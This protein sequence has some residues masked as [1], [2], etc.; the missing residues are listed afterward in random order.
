M[1]DFGTDAGDDAIAMR[2]RRTAHRRRLARISSRL[3][4][5][6]KMRHTSACD[7]HTGSQCICG[8]SQAQ[9]CLA[10]YRV[11]VIHEGEDDWEAL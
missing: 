1:T 11:N 8:L 5:L 9:Y 3:Q 6:G 2:R 10:E 7:H 4:S